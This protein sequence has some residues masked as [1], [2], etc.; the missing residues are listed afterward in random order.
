MIEPKHKL[1]K[2]K[3]KRMKRRTDGKMEESGK[4]VNGDEPM[5]TGKDSMAKY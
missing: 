2:K 5:G 4:T 1:A 3:C